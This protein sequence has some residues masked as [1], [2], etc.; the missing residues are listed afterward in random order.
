MILTKCVFFSLVLSWGRYSLTSASADTNPIC[1][2]TSRSQLQCARGDN[3][4][5]FTCRVGTK[6]YSQ[7][8]PQVNI[9]MLTAKHECTG[10]NCRYCDCEEN[11]VQP[12]GAGLTGKNCDIEFNLCPDNKQ[13]CFHGAPC[14]PVKDN[15]VCGCPYTSDPDR[16]FIG[17]HCEYEADRLC[18]ENNA[19]L[20]DVS[21]SGE[22]FCTNNGECI[23]DETYVLFCDNIIPSPGTVSSSFLDYF[24]YYTSHVVSFLSRFL[25]AEILKTN[26]SVNGDTMDC[27][28][29]IRMNNLI[30]R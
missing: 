14:M 9:A 19:L 18:P 10:S 7:L 24:C 11:D 30:A 28:A 29:N 1:P 21:K 23:S 15:Y 5:P 27:T 6:S 4:A 16:K 20:T 3:N 13:V 22:W 25:N 17:S 8:F 26:A 2:S 12:G